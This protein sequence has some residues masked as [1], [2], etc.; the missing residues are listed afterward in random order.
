LLY[1]FRLKKIKK[2]SGVD[3]KLKKW[4]LCTNSD[5]TTTEIAELQKRVINKIPKNREVK[6]IRWGER[7]IVAILSD[8]KFV[9]IKNLFFGELELS[10]K[11]FKSMFEKQITLVG[12]K[13]ES[14]LH[15][16]VS[17]QRYVNNSL[18]NEEFKIKFKKGVE[19]ILK[20]SDENL[21][22]L[23]QNIKLPYYNLYYGVM[24]FKEFLNSF[25]KSLVKFN[26]EFRTLLMKLDEYKLKNYVNIQN[27]LLFTT[28]DE[29]LKLIELFFK[30]KKDKIDYKSEQID[31]Y[32]F[33][34]KNKDKK[35][36]SDDEFKL[37]NYI[38]IYLDLFKYNDDLQMN[39]GRFKW[40]ISGIL[41]KN[42][43]ILSDAGKGKTNL[44]CKVC[45]SLILKDRPAIYISGKKFVT[46]APL[47][48][49]ILSVLE[50]TNYNISD[51]LNCLDELEIFMISEFLL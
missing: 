48:E 35:R 25:Q 49:Q 46:E 4:F 41:K 37:L 8:P 29:F 28:T 42:V 16:D 9:G 32:E 14:K 18:V 17:K 51:F 38:K 31:I 21:E 5:F 36:L 10:Q 44:A 6:Y 20:L 13:Y 43:T 2:V 33:Y 47:S 34:E 3:P 7:K 11:W 19:E 15:T 26:R 1:F 12:D 40:N 39:I 27:T 24:E 23:N 50:I 45:E 22:T 30:N